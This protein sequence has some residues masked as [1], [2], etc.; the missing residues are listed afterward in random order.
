MYVCICVRSP[1]PHRSILPRSMGHGTD[2]GEGDSDGQECRTDDRDGE[3]ERVSIGWRR[4]VREKR[5]EKEYGIQI[6][7]KTTASQV[8]RDNSVRE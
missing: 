4:R 6:A 3:R 7:G 5:S 2:V 8:A 1:P